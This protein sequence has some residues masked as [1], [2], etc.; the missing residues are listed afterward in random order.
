VASVANLSWVF[1]TGTPENEIFFKQI[2]DIDLLGYTW[3]SK[4][5]FNK[6]NFN[7]N[8]YNLNNFNYDGGGFSINNLL[9]VESVVFQDPHTNGFGLFGG[10]NY[11]SITNLTID[12][13]QLK[14][15]NN[16][17]TALSNIGILSG[18]MSRS[19]L[20]NV[21][22]KNSSID[23][24]SGPNINLVGG[25]SGTVNY[26]GLVKEIS[27]E[28]NSITIR[29]V[30]ANSNHESNQVGGVFGNMAWNDK[31]ADISKIHSTN[32]S[33]DL[34]RRAVHVGG[35]IGRAEYLFHYEGNNGE[36]YSM[37]EVYAENFEIRITQD[38]K[39]NWNWSQ[40]IGGL[41]GSTYESDNGPIK[42][43]EL[44]NAFA[45]GKIYITSP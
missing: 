26:M 9:L 28:N 45:T 40:N 30:D 6:A 2:Q 12:N 10:M 21:S 3:E 32:V 1:D 35:L 4:V 44:Q 38:T 27:S 14:I 18:F 7:R 25:I 37:N 33:I 11:G 31:R 16:G 13:A 20:N 23:I 42:T 34:A 17:T 24:Y 8:E 15:R 39:T 29:G 43:P 36:N 19:F 22:V 41:I 5:N